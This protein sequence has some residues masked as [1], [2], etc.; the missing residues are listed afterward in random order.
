MCGIPLVSSDNSVLD[1]EFDREL[2][3]HSH[4]NCSCCKPLKILGF[5]K[6]IYSE[7]M[8]MVSLKLLYCNFVRSMLEFD[9]V[10]LS[11]R[12]HTQNIV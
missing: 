3:Y 9:A 5:L 4:I 2:N 10:L 12:I 6:R 7:F 8:L 1:L 11:C